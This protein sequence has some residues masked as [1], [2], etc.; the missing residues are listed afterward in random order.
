MWSKYRIY[1][2]GLV[3][4]L[5]TSIFGFLFAAPKNGLYPRIHRQGKE[6]Q[7]KHDWSIVNIVLA[8][9]LLS[10]TTSSSDITVMTSTKYI[11][12]LVLSL[13]TFLEI[14]NLIPF[15]PQNGSKILL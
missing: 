5:V 14:F 3:F 2:A 1:P 13:N 12:Y 15:P 4:T 6:R 11:V 10:I 8:T 9:V 7:G